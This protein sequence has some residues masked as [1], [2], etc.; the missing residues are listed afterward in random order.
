MNTTQERAI[1]NDIANMSEVEESDLF[2]LNTEVFESPPES[3]PSRDQ[4]KYSD[5]NNFTTTTIVQI[6]SDD[7]HDQMYPA[8]R[9]KVDSES[10]SVLEPE[11][12]HTYDEQNA[13]EASGT[14]TVTSQTRPKRNL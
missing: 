4:T 5:N 7:E 11:I 12:L 13:N 8:K 14:A 10:A 6:E 9:P 2:S 1:S 3:L